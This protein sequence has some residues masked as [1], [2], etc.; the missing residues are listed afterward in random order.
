MTGNVW[1]ILFSDWYDFSTNRLNFE[2]E[3]AFIGSP[4]MVPKVNWSRMCQQ[5][6]LYTQCDYC[7]FES[8]VKFANFS[9]L[10]ESSIL[11]SI[12]GNR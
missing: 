1:Q 10:I 3:L 8:K 12:G 5:V 4:G 6:R 11:G 2:L 7:F 9:G